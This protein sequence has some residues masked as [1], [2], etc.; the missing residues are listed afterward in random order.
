MNKKGKSMLGT[1]DLM[2]FV[3]TTQPEKAR[4]FYENTL[5]L[6][7]VSDDEYAMMFE[8]NG[9]R[10]RIARIQ[11]FTPDPFTILGWKVPDITRTIQ[12]LVKK[13]VEF[14]RYGF[15][16]Q[17]DLGVCTFTSGDKVA[18]FKDPDGNT[19]SLTQSDNL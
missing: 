1:C 4:A 14:Q 18:W 17:D 10:L 9:V 2:A 7:L 13:G 5:G 3:P 15:L 6:K 11:Q 19:L 16:H 12:Q 8:A